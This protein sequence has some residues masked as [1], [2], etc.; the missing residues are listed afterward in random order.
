MKRWQSNRRAILAEVFV[1]GMTVREAADALAMALGTSFSIATVRN[2]LLEIGLTPANGTERRRVA[3]KSR[4]EEVMTR[5][6]AGESPRAIAQQL[7]VA[8]DR[9]KSDIQ[10]LVAEGELPAEMIA[11]AFAMRQIDALARYMSVL[12]PD[13]QAAYEKLRMA[14]SIR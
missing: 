7:H 10:A 5:M 13:A 6:L 14:V 9:V 4:R 11:R 8:V 2:D 12:S 1:P 3:T